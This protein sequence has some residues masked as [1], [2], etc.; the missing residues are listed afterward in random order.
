MSDDRLTETGMITTTLN[1]AY[2]IKNNGL[3]VDIDKVSRM[4]SWTVMQAV[5]IFHGIDPTRGLQ[6]KY[7][8][9]LSI[10]KNI[11]DAY[12]V[13]ENAASDNKIPYKGDPALF[14]DWAELVGITVSQELK[15]AV[16]EEG[17]KRDMFEPEKQSRLEKVAASL[18]LEKREEE[19]ESNSTAHDSKTVI[20]FELN[21]TEPKGPFIEEI[22]SILGEKSKAGHTKPTGFELRD[23]LRDNP[24]K[25]P[26]FVR[27]NSRKEIEYRISQCDDS[28]K[29]MTRD[30]LQKVIARHTAPKK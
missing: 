30:A 14:I 3:K 26:H 9:P 29:K 22:K 10:Y 8:K 6:D 2:I 25:A 27:V 17:N 13:M 11:M 19:A 7:L 16:L 28:L 1:E 12:D 21:D 20:L 18:E 4:T 23:Y 5:C 24:N 15:N